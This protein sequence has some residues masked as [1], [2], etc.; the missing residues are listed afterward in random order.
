MGME[1][2][3]GVAS[4]VYELE[5]RERRFRAVFESA[6]DAIVIFDD[7]RRVLEANPAAVSLFGVSL[8]ELKGSRL[9]TFCPTL[10][11]G[12]SPWADARSAVQTRQEFEIVRPDGERRTVETSVTA[13]FV[14]G[15]HVGVV[16]DV[17][18]QRKHERERLRLAE[19]FERLFRTDVVGMAL[20]N[21]Q[22]GRLDDCNRTLATFFGRVPDDFIGRPL[23]DFSSFFAESTHYERL[24]LGWAS[25]AQLQG[26]PIQSALPDGTR[27]QGLATFESLPD[28]DGQG[29]VDV[30]VV[31]DV[32]EQHRLEAELRHVQQL[33]AIG[34]LAGGIAHEFNN[35]LAVI[36]GFAAL[37]EATVAGDP[38]GQDSLGEIKRASN[39]AVKLVHGLLAFSK[40]EVFDL[41]A[42]DLHA[43]IRRTIGALQELLGPQI[44]VRERFDASPGWV[45]TDPLQ[46][47]HALQQLAA[48]ARDAM[49][50]GGT[51]TI[52]TYDVDGEV[53]LSVEDSGT[54]MDPMTLERAFE[55]FFT[56][57][58]LGAGTGLGLS[59]V[60]GIVA[61]SGGRVTADSEP[62]KGTTVHLFLRSSEP[63]SI[64]ARP[65]LP[66][67]DDPAPVVGTETILLVDQ[68]TSVALL[69]ESFLGRLGYRVLRAESVMEAQRIIASHGGRID[70][71][72]GKSGIEALSGAAV[73]EELRTSACMPEL[74]G[75]LI[76]ATPD[77]VE[78]TRF[79]SR[80]A[81]VMEPFVM[82][83]LAV[84]ARRLLDA[85]V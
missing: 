79:G 35:L 37:L 7:L 73:L 63:Q 4:A 14:F 26:V 68:D 65:R 41:R 82:A 3:A 29:P 15:Q 66:L 50:D 85:R 19:R 55:P 56:T 25:G 84:A 74:P 69:I 43:L 57:K 83:D 81:H 33:E 49:P 11:D 76:S 75:I 78:S 21:R 13:D 30:I 36:S 71:V 12:H 1:I 40:Q 51:L 32:T 34:R 53:R 8:E 80:T 48:N 62:G 46:L 18:S 5:T 38:D 10:V 58:P 77:M 24:L 27:R 22:T 6:S 28:V 64:D 2:P 20:V 72:I 54:G 45:D 60:Y 44:E 61:R 70:L 17:T 16:R 23:G 67:Y 39:R 42:V 9:D 59:T 52:R 47:E 31:I